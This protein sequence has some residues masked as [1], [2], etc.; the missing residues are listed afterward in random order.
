MLWKPKELIQQFNEVRRLN[1][2]LS[3]P[4][5][6][7]T[8]S[9]A[10]GEKLAKN[11]M[12]EICEACAKDFDFEH[13]QFIAIKHTDTRHQHFHIIA[14]RIGFDTKTVSDSNNYKKIAN[15]C[16][17]MELKYD[18]QKVLNPRQFLSK[19]MQLKPRLD[20]RK[21][22]LKECIKNA[23][24]Q[25]RDYTEFEQKMTAKGYQIIKGRGI[26]FIDNKKVKV[27]GSE[28]NFSL[29]TIEKILIK[30]ATIP[31]KKE[32]IHQ[33]TDGNIYSGQAGS[34]LKKAKDLFVSE[35]LKKDISKG[36]EELMKPEQNHDLYQSQ[37]LKKQRRKKE[38]RHL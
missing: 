27:K 17:K 34:L 19:E 18:L 21:E 11:K 14:N 6:H 31:I 3:N 9:L 16:R 5:L 2:K 10:P 7:I 13:N 28:I 12:A 25:S 20:M 1:T 36:L 8:L 15:F 26:S 38:H 33:S 29:Q 37:L 30:Q 4:V 35:S 22:A 24:N 32:N 23:L